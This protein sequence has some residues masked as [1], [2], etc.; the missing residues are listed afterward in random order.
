MSGMV[1]MTNGEL[2]RPKSEITKM[3]IVQDK[4]SLYLSFMLQVLQLQEQGFS[5]SI[6]PLENS[7]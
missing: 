6:R 2:T 5:N 4:D 1:S 3:I 7:A